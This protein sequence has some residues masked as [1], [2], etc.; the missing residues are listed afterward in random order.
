MTARKLTPTTL[1]LRKLVNSGWTVDICERQIGNFKKDL[2]GFADLIAFAGNRIILIQ[3]TDYSNS[4]ARVRK[5]H[6]KT[7]ARLWLAGYSREIQVWAWKYD[8]DDQPIRKIIPVTL[9][10]RDWAT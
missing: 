4:S 2:F 5:I 9:D 8:S 1:S 10:D 7:E 3:A 6:G